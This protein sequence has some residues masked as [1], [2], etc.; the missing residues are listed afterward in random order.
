MTHLRSKAVQDDHL[1]VGKRRGNA[2]LRPWRKRYGLDD[3]QDHQ[4]FA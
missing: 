1:D 4:K 2:E 3:D